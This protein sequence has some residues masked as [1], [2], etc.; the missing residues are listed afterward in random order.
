MMTKYFKVYV[1]S[2]KSVEVDLECKPEL[3]ELEIKRIVL[4]FNTI[5]NRNIV[6]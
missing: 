5:N 6:Q 1:F 4:P 2:A 3:P